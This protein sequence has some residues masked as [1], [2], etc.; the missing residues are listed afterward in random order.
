MMK[1]RIA[2]RFGFPPD[3]DK[4]A[5]LPAE[6]PWEAPIHELS[7]LWIARLCTC[8]RSS[9][10]PLRRMAADLGWQRRRPDRRRPWRDRQ[11]HEAG[12]GFGAWQRLKSPSKLR[13]DALRRGESAATMPHA[14]SLSGQYSRDK[15]CP[16]VSAAIEVRP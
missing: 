2:T 9:L 3:R 16:A 8:G 10:Y 4:P 6:V 13:A 15:C 5:S 14:C 12:A 1:D 7:G 11:C